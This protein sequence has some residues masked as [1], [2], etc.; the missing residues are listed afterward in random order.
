MIYQLTSP[1]LANKD[2]MRFHRDRLLAESDWAMLADAPTDKQAWAEY[3]QALRDFPATWEPGA[4]ADFPNPPGWTEP[5]IVE[6]E[7]VELPVEPLA[8]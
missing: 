4:V 8:E 5:A 7:P 6:V 1:I 3:R 2:E